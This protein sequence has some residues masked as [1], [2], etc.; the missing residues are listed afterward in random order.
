MP[1]KTSPKYSGDD[2]KQSSSGH[3]GVA[4]PAAAAAAAANA[5]RQRTQSNHSDAADRDRDQRRA[6]FTSADFRD[7]TAE[8]QLLENIEGRRG[9]GRAASGELFRTAVPGERPLLG[10]NVSFDKM[11]NVYGSESSPPSGAGGMGGS[12]SGGLGGDRAESSPLASSEHKKPPR[13]SAIARKIMMKRQV[14]KALA[15]QRMHKRAN[16]TAHVLLESIQETTSSSSAAFLDLNNSER[17]AAVP[18]S[19][20]GDGVDFFA[21][22][23][24]NANDQGRSAFAVDNTD[25]DRL[26]SGAMQVEKLFEDDVSVGSDSVITPSASQD[27][28]PSRLGDPLIGSGNANQQ[29]YGS[30]VRD[31]RRARRHSRRFWRKVGRCYTECFHPVRNLR[32]IVGVAESAYFLWLSLPLFAAA[33]IL[34]YYFG[35]PELDFMP[36]NATISWWLNFLGRHLITHELARATE[37]LVIDCFALGSRFTVRL[38]GPFLTLLAIQGKGWPFT[39]ASWGVWNLFLLHGDGTF[40]THWLYWTGFEIYSKANSGSYILSS[41]LYLRVLLTMLMAGVAASV[42]RTVV[43]VYF[44]RRTFGTYLFDGLFLLTLALDWGWGWIMYRMHTSFLLFIVVIYLEH[45]RIQAKIG[46]DSQRRCSS[47]GGGG[48]C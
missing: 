13:L 14:A 45:S 31:M 18:E 23:G 3:H 25:T 6:S 22:V 38:F 34:Y 44:G 37:W 12:G 5:A 2:K 15:P 30:T 26:I 40:Q 1:S 19:P 16:S 33:W 46:K 42:K 17:V 41:D 9:H 48:S 24:E 43:A 32:R 4:A 29:H 8:D 35:N 10:T 20:S 47:C 39:I 21:G 11:Y 27:N 36:G 7:S 28:L